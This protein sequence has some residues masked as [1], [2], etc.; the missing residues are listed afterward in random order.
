MVGV[1]KPFQLLCIDMKPLYTE[2]QFEAALTSDRLPC[3]CTVC[4]GTF[5]KKKKLILEAIK[6]YKQQNGNY[7]SSKCFHTT[8]TKPRASKLVACSNCGIV[9]QKAPSQIRKT[10]NHFC[11][12]SCSGTYNNTH[13]THGTRRSKLEVWLEQQ[14][15]ALYP[16]L[17]FHFN[18]KDAINA[19][20][21]IYVPSLKLAFELNGLFHYEPIFGATKL[22]QIQTNDER[23]YQAC[24]E[25]DIELCLI[26]V[27]ALKKFKEKRA[28]T[29]L[30][31]IQ[32]VIQRKFGAYSSRHV[33]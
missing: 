4:D 31:V 7:C 29:F 8:R 1:E 15:I 3:Q 17:E 21:D 32:D 33:N 14:L 25:R 22:A 28:I 27:S 5:Y 24:I 2:Q 12:M 19:E 10:N 23:K 26:D 16:S 11:T 9:F 18:R 30:I 20:L 13:K 6:G